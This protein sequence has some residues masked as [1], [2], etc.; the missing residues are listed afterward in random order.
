MLAALT[1]AASAIVAWT[2]TDPAP[3]PRKRWP[4]P[5]SK[6]AGVKVTPVTVG[7]SRST[8]ITCFASPVSDAAWPAASLAE[9]WNCTFALAG[10]TE[11]SI[12]IENV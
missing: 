12:G 6:A 3:G 10:A 1:P 5:S 4:A 11:S 9:I 2:E 8:L 7:A